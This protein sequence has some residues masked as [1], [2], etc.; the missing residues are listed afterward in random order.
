[1][2]AHHFD[3]NFGA[4]L[5]LLLTST[6]V[7]SFKHPQQSATGHESAT[8]FIMSRQI[9][10]TEELLQPQTVC[11]IASVQQ[12]MVELLLTYLYNSVMRPC[13]SVM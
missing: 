12:P 3:Y 13:T 9:D 5:R 11:C 7:A 10:V 1:L 6:H 8:Q 2:F 4:G